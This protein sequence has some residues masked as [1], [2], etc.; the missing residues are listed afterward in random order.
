MYYPVYGMVHIQN[1]L[2]LIRMEGRKENALFNDVLNTF[3][4]Y[5]YMAQHHITV[6]YNG[7]SMLLTK[8]FPSLFF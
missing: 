8:T 4:I 6:K 1:P 7:S 5:G 2:P 3:S